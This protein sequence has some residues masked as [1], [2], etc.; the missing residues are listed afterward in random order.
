MW[1]E[2]RKQEKK[3]REVIVDYQKRAERRREHYEKL[4]RTYVNV[5]IVHVI[6]L[7]RKLHGMVMLYYDFFSM[8]VRMIVQIYTY[9]LAFACVSF[10]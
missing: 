3:V 8:G 4:V 9:W 6:I 10:I 1:H 5:C 2:A 7:L